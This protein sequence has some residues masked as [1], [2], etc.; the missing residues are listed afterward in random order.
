MRTKLHLDLG[1]RKYD[2][3]PQVNVL[4]LAGKWIV[5]FIAWKS[6]WQVDKRMIYAQL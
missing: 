4:R 3:P 5:H 6:N 2:A 1:Y